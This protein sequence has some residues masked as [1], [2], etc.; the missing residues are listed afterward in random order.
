MVAKQCQY[1]IIRRGKKSNRMNESSHHQEQDSE[2]QTHTHTQ[3]RK[4]AMKFENEIGI[5]SPEPSDTHEQGA[6]TGERN[7][8]AQEDQKKK[9]RG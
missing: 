7:T 1:M 2:T 3:A 8:R 9:N 4:E 6:H 5:P